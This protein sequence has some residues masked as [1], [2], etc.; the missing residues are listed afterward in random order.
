MTAI[1]S[2]ADPPTVRFVGY[3]L[4]N[5]L[6]PTEADRVKR[7]VLIELLVAARPDILGVCEIGELDAV[8]ELQKQLADSGVD[9]P[10]IEWVEGSSERHL[11]LLSRFPILSRQSRPHLTYQLN[12]M[13][14]PVSRGFLD[15][16]IQVAPDYEVRCLGAH[17]K[18]RR[19]VAVADQALIR[20]NEAHLLRQHAERILEAEPHANLLVYGDFNDTRDS[21]SIRAIQGLSGSSTYLRAL[22]LQDSS[23]LTWT[24]YWD[25]ADVYSRID[26]IFVSQ[27]LA[28]EIDHTKSVILDHRDWKLASDHRALVA[29]FVTRNQ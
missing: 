7:S 21:P 27:G 23:G 14:L 18:S 22:A 16:T 5:Y 15:V 9:L 12:E 2:A 3:N 29:T 19:E 20:R 6:E 13:E 28:R 17:L 11:A 10:Y 1:L 24:H 26:F 4:E 25:V 8:A